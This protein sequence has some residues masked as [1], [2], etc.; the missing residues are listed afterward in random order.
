MITRSVWSPQVVAHGDWLWSRSVVVISGPLQGGLSWVPPGHLFRGWRSKR[1][2][3]GPPLLRDDLSL[4]GMC[5]DVFLPTPSMFTP[6]T[7]P[8]PTWRFESRRNLV[9]S[10][11]ARKCPGSLVSLLCTSTSSSVEVG[12]HCRQSWRQQLDGQSSRGCS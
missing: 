9:L 11:G 7:M 12:Q 1:D 10:G 3:T 5:Q 2:E 6:H 8:L 4:I